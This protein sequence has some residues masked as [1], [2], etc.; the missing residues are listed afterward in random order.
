MPFAGELLWIGFHFNNVLYFDLDTWG[1]GI[2]LRRSVG[3]HPVIGEGARVWVK[4]I[5]LQLG[6]SLV[7]AEMGIGATAGDGLRGFGQDAQGRGGLVRRRIRPGGGQGWLIPPPAAWPTGNA[8]G[9]FG[10]DAEGMADMPAGM[11]FGSGFP[12]IAK[13]LRT[14]R[15]MPGASCPS[16]N[17]WG[18][19]GR[20]GFTPER[21][22]IPSLNGRAFGWRARLGQGIGWLAQNPRSRGG[23]GP[24]AMVWLSPG[25]IQGCLTYACR[26]PQVL[27]RRI[28]RNPRPMAIRRPLHRI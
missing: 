23:P 7:D 18:R 16:A 14:T 17:V 25:C 22:P 8:A 9:G 12:G 19:Y 4:A 1:R 3:V 26:A 6:D 20:S 2:R 27:R 24:R 13:G 11:C 21:A 28:G 5:G 15:R 10:P